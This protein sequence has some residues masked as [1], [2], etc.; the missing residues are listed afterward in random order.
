MDDQ[1]L[2]GAGLNRIARFMLDPR[3]QRSDAE[4]FD[5]VAGK[6]GVFGCFGLMACADVC[7]KELPLLDVYSYLRRKRLTA[8]ST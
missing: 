4:W 3:D 5:V 2:A 1:F 7:P 8:L 6:E